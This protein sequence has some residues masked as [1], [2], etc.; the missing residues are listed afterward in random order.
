MNPLLTS[1]SNPKIKQ[2]MSLEKARERRKQD[3]FIIE[4]QRELHL[5]KSANYQFVNIFYCP[6]IIEE[7][8][9][10][11]QGF[12][13]QIMIP[14]SHG[15]F[16]KIA[17]RGTTGGVVAVAQ[18]KQNRLEDLKLG[19]N[20]LILVLES[21]EKPGNL[22]AVLRTADAAGVDAV[23]SCDGETDFY[24][25]NTVRS[26]LGGVFTNQIASASSSETIAWLKKHN[27][28]IYCTY[29]EA[30]VDYTKVD[31]NQP[32]AIVMGS[33]A[34]GLTRA[35]VENSDTNIIIP[36]KG[37][38]DSMNVSVSAAIVVFEALRQRAD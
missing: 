35:W 9:L 30:S 22:G 18:Q 6:D 33:E 17:Y 28:K 16:E 1:T 4:G 20:P 27:I 34:Q 25:P 14:V 10:L 12:N 37:T 36:M 13:Q 32:C 15:V 2:L 8:E 5:A 3:Q 7:S 19:A 38:I 26:S 31:F 11:K 23:I 21:I 29:L 24:N